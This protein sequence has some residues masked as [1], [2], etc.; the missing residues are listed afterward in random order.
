MINQMPKINQSTSPLLKIS[1]D[2]SKNLTTKIITVPVIVIKNILNQLSL[3]FITP[4]FLGG[5]I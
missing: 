3:T 4:T 1:K 5:L 2:T